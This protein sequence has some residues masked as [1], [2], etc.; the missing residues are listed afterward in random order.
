MEIHIFIKGRTHD[1]TREFVSLLILYSIAL[2]VLLLKNSVMKSELV[3]GRAAYE[4]IP[5]VQYHLCPRCFPY[6]DLYC[7]ICEGHG[8]Y[9]NIDSDTNT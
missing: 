3:K 6:I 1:Q 5:N 9:L 7:E 8:E 2:W 4:S